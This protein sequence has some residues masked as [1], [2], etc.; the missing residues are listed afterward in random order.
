MIPVRERFTSFIVGIIEVNNIQRML[1]KPYLFT[2][3]IAIL[4]KD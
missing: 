4:N 3:P 2:V 1:I